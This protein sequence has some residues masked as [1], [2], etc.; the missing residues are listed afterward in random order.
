MKTKS[1][2]EIPG[3]LCPWL[4]MLCWLWVLYPICWLSWAWLMRFTFFWMKFSPDGSDDTS[5]AIWSGLQDLTFELLLPPVLCFFLALCNSRS[6]ST[7]GDFFPLLLKY[8]SILC[9]SLG[10]DIDKS[11]IKY[12]IWN[13]SNGGCYFLF[14]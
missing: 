11:N 2:D 9:G 3:L 1:I 10:G 8:K 5:D 13:D 14:L 6:L 7:T 4:W 12:Y